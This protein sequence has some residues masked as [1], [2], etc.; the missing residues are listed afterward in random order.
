VAR[1]NKNIKVCSVF[2]IFY[3]SNLHC[4]EQ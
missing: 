2:D 3:L 1:Q 4:L